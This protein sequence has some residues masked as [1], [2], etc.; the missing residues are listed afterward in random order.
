MGAFV[1]LPGKDIRSKGAF[2]SAL[3]TGGL[4]F[5]DGDFLRSILSIDGCFRG[6][7]RLS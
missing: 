2:A 3:R 1:D 4:S 5:R 7:E 6:R